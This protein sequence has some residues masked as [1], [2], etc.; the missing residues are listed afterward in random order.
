M[1]QSMAARLPLRFDSS[2]WTEKSGGLIDGVVCVPETRG[3]APTSSGACGCVLMCWF[4]SRRR[5]TAITHNQ[6]TLPARFNQAGGHGGERRGY[7]FSGRGS[8]IG[9]VFA[10]RLLPQTKR[11]FNTSG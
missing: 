1:K 11:H 4:G 10:Y 2:G 8:S 5:P 3:A 7:P 9:R 6:P